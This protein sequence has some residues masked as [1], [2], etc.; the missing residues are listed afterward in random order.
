MKVLT[1]TWVNVRRMLRERSNI[2]FVFIFPIALI[3][4]IGVQF[5]GG[6]EPSVGLTLADDD[7]LAVSIAAELRQAEGF[8]TE[9]FDDEG[10][11]RTAVER[12]S[13]QAGVFL[14]PNMA[15]TA[16]TGEP[17]SIEY[18][19]RSDGFSAQLQSVVRSAIASVMK[20]VGAAQFAVD[21]S[22]TPFSEALVVARDLEPSVGAVEVEVDTTGEALFP[23]SLGQF[24]L[25]A[26]QQLVLFVFLTA[27][28]GGSALIL[29]R[30][31]GISQRMLSTPTS[32]WT[33]VT[34]EAGGRFGVAL[35]QG[36][37]IMSL[38]LVIFGVNWGCLL[39]T[40]PSPR[41]QRGSRM[42]SSA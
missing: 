8:E 40:S 19:G 1:I 42:P 12:G 29:T 11:L 13:V 34:G 16:A 4:L 3:L 38:T 5:G 28:A 23:A 15:A 33:I 31:L 27:F 21:Q 14:P 24:D 20:P 7:D 6:I 10:E 2:F 25:G 41:D 17:I 39:Y 18:V 36:L 26:A 37:Y 32:T 30:Q 22:E 35:T 9:D